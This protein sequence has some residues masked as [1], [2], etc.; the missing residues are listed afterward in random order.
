VNCLLPP[1]YLLS[2]GQKHTNLDES[3]RSSVNQ[4]EGHLMEQDIHE[5]SNEKIT[6]SYDVNRCIHAR[7]CV[8]NLPSV[9]DPDRR[10]WIDPNNA[11]INELTDVIMQCP[12]GAL[13]FDRTDDGPAEPIPEKNTV[14]VVPNGPLYLRGDIEIA[15]PDNTVLLAD[16]RVGLC[17][18]G[19]SENKPLC[20]NSHEAIDF[21]DNGTVKSTPDGSDSSDG[22]TLRVV[23]TPNG[24]VLLR[25]EFEIR[26]RDDEQSH[27]SADAALCRCGGSQDK[28]FCDGT[29]DAIGFST[30][31]NE[32]SSDIDDYPDRQ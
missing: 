6:V 30:E 23:P 19:A 10:P 27:R 14:T 12:T 28:P 13:Q 4:Q 26:G 21:Q 2:L 18:C 25:G 11:D 9:F 3:D 8:R 31:D 7:E 32:G 29:H 24:P 1:P 15:T 22:E 20:D 17:R 5:Y 16:T